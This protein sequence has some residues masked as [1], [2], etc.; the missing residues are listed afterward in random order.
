MTPWHALAVLKLVLF[1]LWPITVS[2][3]VATGTV[4]PFVGITGMH[5][6]VLSVISTLSGL[7]ALTIRIDSELKKFKSNQLPRPKLFVASHMLGS[8]LAGILGVVISQQNE[9]TVW[10]QI[11]LVIVASFMGAKFIE[12]MSE[13]YVGKL[14]KD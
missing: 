11:A 13:I 7:T 14:G 2:A 3:A 10:T 12:K 1:M 4:D 6:L 5:V 9:F 8:W